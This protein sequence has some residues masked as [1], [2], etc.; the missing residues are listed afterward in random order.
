MTRR[1]GI[2]IFPEVEVLDFTGPFEVFNT[3]SRLHL[4]TQPDGQAP[5]HVEIIAET[6]Q[7]IRARGG[8]TIIP[9]I[10]I[11]TVRKLD[12]LV[13]PGGVVSEELAKPA[14][15]S[16]MRSSHGGTEITASV[17]TGAFI[18]AQ[19]GILDGL[20]VTTHWED[21]EELAAR[22]P[23]LTVVSGRRW[24]QQG[25]VVTAAGISAGIDV[26]LHLVAQLESVDLAQR[27]ARQ[28]EYDWT[29]DAG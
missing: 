15:L 13:V 28:M 19:A 11:P 29:P 4:R 2:Y 18:L 20:H 6:E 1:V 27:T 5:F 16:W 10:S 9:D 24:I 12:V 3:A 22:Y 17:C 21:I 14:L 25:K 23:N 8:L 7:P 26:S